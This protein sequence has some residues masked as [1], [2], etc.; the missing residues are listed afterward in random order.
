MGVNPRPPQCECGAL[1]TELPALI[2]IKLFN[3]SE[4]RAS[5]A[6]F[7]RDRPQSQINQFPPNNPSNPEWAS[8]DLA[9]ELTHD[10]TRRKPAFFYQMRLLLKRTLLPFE[11]TRYGRPPRPAT[12]AEVRSRK[13][14]TRFVLPLPQSPRPADL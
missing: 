1:P 8:L 14:R 5:P 12:T 11:W 7:L 13:P 4:I 2:I 3:L 6:R 9:H 10:K